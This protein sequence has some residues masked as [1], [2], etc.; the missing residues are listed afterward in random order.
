MK[1]P[2]DMNA[3]E[4]A[5]YAGLIE[6]QIRHPFTD[7]QIEARTMHSC[8][9][10]SDDIDDD[11]DFCPSCCDNHE[12]VWDSAIEWADCIHCRKPAPEDNFQDQPG[13]DLPQ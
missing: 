2:E 11:Q 10:C 12:Y 1:T 7:D 5:A 13:D 4:R 3:M 6:T 9:R 8:P